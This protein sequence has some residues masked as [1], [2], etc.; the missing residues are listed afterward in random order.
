MQSPTCIEFEERVSDLLENRLSPDETAAL[1]LH[2]RGCPD[3]G[4]LLEMV[5]QT[6]RALAE[7]PDVEPPAQLAAAIRLRTIGGRSSISW[8][9]TLQ[10]LWQSLWHP[11]AVMALASAIFTFGVVLNSIGV[12]LNGLRPSD[13]APKNIV[14]AAVAGA[15]RTIANGERYYEN[16]KTV[17]RIEAAL[18]SMSE[19]E[20]TPETASPSTK[21][22]KSDPPVNQRGNSPDRLP[23][24]AVGVPLAITTEHLR[25]AGV[26]RMKR[27]K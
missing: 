3:C 12:H 24:L 5:G 11:R 26:L 9:A 1:R 15:S 7:I 13:L 21:P 25:R 20:P 27:G 6:V 10:S 23:V 17:Y 2:A 18:R 16:L 4:A 22:H 19:P 8:S 14:T